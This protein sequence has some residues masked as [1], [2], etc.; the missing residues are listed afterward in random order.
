MLLSTLMRHL[1]LLV[2]MDPSAGDLSVE[3]TTV[4]SDRLFLVLGASTYRLDAIPCPECGRE[5]PKDMSCKTCNPD[6]LYRR[7]HEAYGYTP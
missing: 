3:I 7:N 1:D 6:A 5:C 4:R 2:T